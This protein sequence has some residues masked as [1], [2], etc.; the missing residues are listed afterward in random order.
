M[1]SPQAITIPGICGQS[2]LPKEGVPAAGPALF[3]GGK[4]KYTPRL[5]EMTAS[6]KSTT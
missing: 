5:T 1:V 2:G 4:E 3:S 6:K